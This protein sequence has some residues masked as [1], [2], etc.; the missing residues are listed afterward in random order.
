M[1][2]CVQF[3]HLRKK[4][5]DNRRSWDTKRSTIPW[6]QISNRSISRPIHS[7]KHHQHSSPPSNA[8]SQSRLAL[9]RLPLPSSWG[10]N[11]LQSL[12]IQQVQRCKVTSE[13][14]KW[15]NMTFGSGK[16]MKRIKRAWKAK[17]KCPQN[18]LISIAEHHIRENPCAKLLHS[19]SHEKLGEPSP[20]LLL[21]VFLYDIHR[22]KLNMT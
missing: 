6:L 13:R 1:S 3:S 22:N 21:I 18:L 5:Q 14:K 16:S 2:D 12:G 8:C 20:R 11:T 15:A 4:T 19:S 7:T 17:R 9:H 10:S